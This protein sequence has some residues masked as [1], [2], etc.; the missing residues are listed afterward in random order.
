MTKA[1]A[2]SYLRF[3]TPDQFKGDSFRRQ[4]VMAE[5]YANKHGLELQ[6]LRFKDL[7]VSGFKG[8]NLKAGALG[9]FKQEVES[10]SINPNSWLLIE[11][12]DRFSRMPT[13]YVLPEMLSLIDMGIT[14]VTLKNGGKVH[15]KGNL[16]MTTLLTC[17]I[18]MSQ[19]N[20]FSQNLV[21]RI[22]AAK[23]SKRQ[24]IKLT[25]TGRMSSNC[26]LWMKPKGSDGFEL[27]EERAA[28]VKKIFEL[29]IEGHGRKAVCNY[30]TKN[31][32]KPFSPKARTWHTSYIEKI[33]KNHQAYGSVQ[34]YKN[35]EPDGDP[36]RGYYPAAVS[37]DV[38]LAALHATRKR[39]IADNKGVTRKSRVN[40]FSGL[41][42]CKCGDMLRLKN[43]GKGQFYYKC[44]NVL[45]HRGCTA[46]TLKQKPTDEM[47]IQALYLLGDKLV[48]SGGVD[49]EDLSNVEAIRLK[50]ELI[51]TESK[52]DVAMNR[53]LEFDSDA[54]SSAFRALDEEV[55][56][57][58][59]RLNVLE[60]ETASVRVSLDTEELGSLLDNLS[61]TLNGTCVE[62]KVKT[63]NALSQVVE[64]IEFGNGKVAVQLKTKLPDYFD[65]MP[66]RDVL[67]IFIKDHGKTWATEGLRAKT[68]ESIYSQR[69]PEGFKK[70]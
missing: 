64:R 22:S 9:R 27:I 41:L 14:I 44:I 51:K 21:R 7:G 55:K 62:S 18:E 30:L 17:V 1:Q 60:Q 59:S 34:L 31:E 35:R 26:P 19:A 23:E 48:I 29:T 2:Y 43:N 38:Y 28:V 53:L 32:V 24:S 66:K 13:E 8:M 61:D 46:R 12:W 68:E 15:R 3:S 42:W 69:K 63:A 40:I 39:K 20:E 5:D 49:K 70:S 52:R 4:T 65:D 16:D 6:E 11:A 45:E 67:N 54:L 58:Q 33:L 36:I 47:L 10:G 37:E 57:L 25:G 50:E 56:T